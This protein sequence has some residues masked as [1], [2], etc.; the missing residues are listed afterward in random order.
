[1]SKNYIC[2]I[3]IIFSETYIE[4]L[5]KQ[6]IGGVIKYIKICNLSDAVIELPSIE[7]QK[8]IS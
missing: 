5:R 6:A 4:E 7:K 3:C 2:H 1:M 8:K